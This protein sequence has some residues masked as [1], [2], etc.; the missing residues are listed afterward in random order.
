MDILKITLKN[1]NKEELYDVYSDY[2][3]AE[4]TGNRSEKIYEI[5]KEIQNTEDYKN[6]QVYIIVDIVTNCILKEICNRYF[7][8]K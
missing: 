1:M 3:E 2:L 5:A 8:K 6:M 4:R 7:L